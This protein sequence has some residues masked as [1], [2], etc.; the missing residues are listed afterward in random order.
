MKKYLSV[1]LLIAF[2]AIT[3][4]ACKDLKSQGPSED[5]YRISREVDRREDSIKAA[6]KAQHDEYIRQLVRDI[7]KSGSN[8]RNYKEPTDGKQIN[9]IVDGKMSPL[10][11]PKSLSNT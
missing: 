5:F 9:H 10:K 11:N 4:A 1:I 8:G 7:V 3:L 2:A 6:Q